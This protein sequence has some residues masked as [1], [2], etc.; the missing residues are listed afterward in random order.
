MN[1]TLRLNV[2]LTIGEL[3]RYIETNHERTVVLLDGSNRVHAVVT[4][5]DILRAIW[6]GKTISDPITYVINS[7]PILMPANAVV[8]SEALHLFIEQGLLVIPVVDEQRV[9][10]R[11][12][13]V[14]DL[15]REM[16]R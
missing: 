3:I 16:Q 15:L 9:F 8:E 12:I 2:N 14:R 13:Y 1:E 4:Q 10:V 5:G 6:H 11:N 7:N